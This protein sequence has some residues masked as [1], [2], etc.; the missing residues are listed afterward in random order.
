[1]SGTRGR[2]KRGLSL[3]GTMGLRGMGIGKATM[4]GRMIDFTI[5]WVSMCC[6]MYRSGDSSSEFSKYPFSHYLS[7][8]FLSSHHLLSDP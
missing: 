2:I 7:P 3:E 1:M 8:Y 4:M 6:C 5:G